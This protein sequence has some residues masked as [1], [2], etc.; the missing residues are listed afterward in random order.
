MSAY[1]TINWPVRSVVIL[2]QDHKSAGW[3]VQITKIEPGRVVGVYLFDGKTRIEDTS[4]K[5]MHDPTLFN[6]E[7]WHAHSRAL[8]K[9]LKAPN[10]N[11]DTGGFI[12][13]QRFGTA[14][15]AQRAGVHKCR[16]RPSERAN[17]RV[18]NG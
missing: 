6:I 13:G 14:P 5:N 17:R 8:I 15:E 10:V 7:L 12:L 2:E 11:S 18:A 3:L 4:L 16:P 9:N 1:N